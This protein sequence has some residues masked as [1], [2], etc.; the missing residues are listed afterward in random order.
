MKPKGIYN[1]KPDLNTKTGKYF[2]NK[3]KGLTKVKSAELAGF[4]Q[5]EKHTHQIEQTA[6]YKAIERKHYSEVLQD[7]ITIEQIADEQIKVIKQDKDLG[8]KNKAI[9]MAVNKIEPEDQ[10]PDEEKVIVVMR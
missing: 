10:K 6:L 3:Q 9:E 1:K 7:K 4:A 8:A 5:P 2:L